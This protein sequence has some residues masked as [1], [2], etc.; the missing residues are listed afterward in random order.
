MKSPNKPRAYM[1][2]GQSLSEKGFYAE[3]VNFLLKALNT[4]VDG[5]VTKEEI[6]R[7]LGVSLYKMGNLDDAISAYREGLT[8]SPADFAL[9]NNLSIAFMDKGDLEQAEHFA[10]LSLAANSM[11]G[12]ANN[13]MGSIYFRK[14]EYSNAVSYF[15]KAVELNPDIPSRYMNAA[16][17]FENLAD[18]NKAYDY[19]LQYVNM[20]I[21]EASRQSAL[22]KINKLKP[23]LRP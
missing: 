12:D 4:P 23:L 16:L 11:S 6:F 20:E 14:G 9:L 19:Y 10:R 1:N 18:F 13:T 8:Y 17:A 3:S 21:D 2:L 5:S 22:L 15:L 7:E